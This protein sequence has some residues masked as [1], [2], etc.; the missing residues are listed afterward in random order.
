MVEGVWCLVCR[1]SIMLNGVK[2]DGRGGLMCNW[3]EVPAQTCEPPPEA[4]DVRCLCL[5]TDYRMCDDATCPNARTGALPPEDDE[6]A[7]LWSC[8]IC[9]AEADLDAMTPCGDGGRMCPKCAASAAEAFAACDHEWRA[10][11][12]DFGDP[13]H[14]C[15]R[16]SHMVCDEDFPAMFG[17]PAPLRRADSAAGVTEVSDMQS[18]IDMILARH[19]EGVT[20]TEMRNGLSGRGV[21]R[22]AAQIEIGR[23]LDEGRIILGA[24]L[25]LFA[26]GALAGD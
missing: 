23:A 25:K 14:F 12:D 5:P 20:A 24:E 15:M 4:R 8:E 22:G 17:Q 19:P 7:E 1:A 9:G 6:G 10:D 2:S 21:S 18:V 16:C 3:H 26:P 11:H 13:S